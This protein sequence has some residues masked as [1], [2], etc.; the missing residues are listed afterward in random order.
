MGL[1]KATVA[2]DH[3]ARTRHQS[4]AFPVPEYEQ[5]L[6]RLRREMEAAGLSHVL[7]Y[8]NFADPGHIRW[9]SGFYTCHG[10]SFVVVPLDGEPTLVTNWVM[11]DEPMHSEIWT[12]WMRDVR[13]CPPFSTDLVDEVAAALAAAGAPRRVG[14]AGRRVMPVPAM[15]ALLGRIDIPFTDADPLMSRARRVKSPLEI[16]KIRRSSEITGIGIRTALAMLAPGVTEQAAAAAAHGAMFAAGASWLAFESAL[17]SGPE[18][19]GFKHCAPG[20]RA[21]ED[22]DLVFID[23]GVILDG[24]YSDVSRCAAVGE[25]TQEGR[26]LLGAGET[27]YAELVQLARPGKALADLHEDAIRIARELGYG[28]EYMPGGFG[29]G[30]GCMLFESPSLRYQE[31]TDVLEVGMTFAFEPM[32]VVEGLG[33]GVVEDVMLVTETGVEPLS[34][35]PTD[36]YL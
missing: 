22:G 8:G 24:Y 16:A 28:R 2:W 25:P 23:M 20:W 33:T 36:L 3:A 21:F 19:A 26:R 15:E 17:S 34:G 10:D 11:H 27:L 12:T 9:L 18:R 13:C 30:I 14:L 32:I 5:R 7:V 29:H 6:T 35:L 31:T 1:V 4:L